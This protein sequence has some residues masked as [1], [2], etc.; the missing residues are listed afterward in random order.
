ML[1]CFIRNN[2]DDDSS[3]FFALYTILLVPCV[4]LIYSLY[5]FIRV[6]QKRKVKTDK[7]FKLAIIKYLIYSA[8]Y[9]IFYFPTIILYFLTINK[10]IYEKTNLSYFSYFCAIANISVNLVLCV[11]KILEGYVKFEWNPIK[12]LLEDSI[13]TNSDSKDPL[14]NSNID[15]INVEEIRPR[16]KR[17]SSKRVGGSTW[18]KF[19]SEMIKGVKYNNLFIVY[20]RFLYWFNLLFRSIQKERSS[21]ENNKK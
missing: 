15:T 9:I 21:R 8:L 14:I 19:S 7:E 16:Y 3:K 17:G 18:G 20:E 11:F 2:F 4:Y 6:F 13:F 10:D 5:A 1:T 12:N